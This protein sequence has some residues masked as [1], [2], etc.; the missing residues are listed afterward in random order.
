MPCQPRHRP[1]V[2][3]PDGHHLDQHPLHELDAVVLV[4]YARLDH[5][6]DVVDRQPVHGTAAET[7]VSRLPR[8]PGATVLRCRTTQV[9][10]RQLPNRTNQVP[11]AVEAGQR[12]TLTV[13]GEAVADI[14]PYRRRTRWLPGDWLAEQLEH[15]AADPGLRAELDLAGQTVDELD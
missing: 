4:Q 15:R 1:V 5:P 14:V 13:S 8:R 3:G 11:A 2:L 9:G 7:M 10:V 6:K 12:V